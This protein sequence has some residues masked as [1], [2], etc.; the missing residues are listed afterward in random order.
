M[1][2]FPKNS[3]ALFP[4]KSGCKSGWS[5]IGTRQ[6]ISN[7][8]YKSLSLKIG[9][10][11]GPRPP[12]AEKSPNFFK[13]A[14]YIRI[15]LSRILPHPARAAVFG[16]FKGFFG[17]LSGFGAEVGKPADSHKSSWLKLGRSSMMTLAKP[18]FR[19]ELAACAHNL[20]FRFFAPQA[21]KN[22][23]FLRPI[24][25]AAASILLAINSFYYE[26]SYLS[27]FAKRY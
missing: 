13:I 9:K 22:P 12:P 19:L 15:Y 6:K 14:T 3:C 21:A 4:T 8:R 27:I 10:K 18:D 23:V 2:N 16:A 17:R 20:L 11:I 25:T 5:W 1:G 26:Y 24:C 7:S